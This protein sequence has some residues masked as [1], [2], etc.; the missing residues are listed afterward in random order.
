[1]ATK[2]VEADTITQAEFVTVKLADYPDVCFSRLP[3]FCQSV[4]ES[5]K[6]QTVC[7]KV[8]TYIKQ[9]QKGQFEKLPFIFCC[10]AGAKVLTVTLG[11]TVYLIFCRS[12]LVDERHLDQLTQGLGLEPGQVK[13][14]E[15]LWKSL[16][17]FGA[18]FVQNAI[19]KLAQKTNKDVPENIQTSLEKLASAYTQFE[20]DIAVYNALLPIGTHNGDFKGVLKIDITLTKAD[21]LVVRVITKILGPH[22]AELPMPIIGL[23]FESS[24]FNSLENWLESRL[25]KNLEPILLQEWA[26][27][28]PKDFQYSGFDNTA[29]EKWKAKVGLYLDGQPTVKWTENTK[30]LV[31]V[32]LHRGGRTTQQFLSQKLNPDAQVF[33]RWLSYF[34]KQESSPTTGR[35][36]IFQTHTFADLY[37]VLT[38]RPEDAKDWLKTRIQQISDI[39]AFAEAEEY[40]LLIPAPQMGPEIDSEELLA[41]DIIYGSSIYRDIFRQKLMPKVLAYYLAYHNRDSERVMLLIDML[42]DFLGMSCMGITVGIVPWYRISNW[43]RKN[44]ADMYIRRLVVQDI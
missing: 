35:Q 38:R 10:H 20:F 25:N 23:A 19:D 31:Q 18:R 22:A 27:R 8:G 2:K 24:E 5:P 3:R 41:N 37:A 28:E 36:Q 12:P 33:K 17:R 34:S 39:L 7:R 1:M 32:G 4:C 44:L 21:T 26:D 6:G 9:I 29:T 11:E 42:A 16:P 13:K 15:K 14:L 30:R 43:V 40:P